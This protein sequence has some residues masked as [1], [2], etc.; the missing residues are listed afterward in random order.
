MIGQHENKIKD[1]DG[2]YPKI[3]NIIKSIVKLELEA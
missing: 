2:K 3:E 1:Y